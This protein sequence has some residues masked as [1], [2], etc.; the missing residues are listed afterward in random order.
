M[1]NFISNKNFIVVFLVF[2]FA[3]SADAATFT[4][5][6]TGDTADIS[7]GDGICADAAGVCTLRAAIQEANALAGTDT[8]A[9][10]ITGPGVQTISP[11]SAYPVI[12][13]PLLID[14][15][16]QGGAGYTGPPLI[17][18]NG[19]NAGSGSEGFVFTGGS[20]LLRGIVINRFPGNGVDLLHVGG[21]TVSGCYIGTDSGGTVDLGNGGH[22]IAIISQ[23]NTSS[24]NHIIG[25]STPVERNI[26]SGNAFKGI[27]IVGPSNNNQ[28]KG[29]FIGTD[30]TGTADLGNTHDGVEITTGPTGNIVGGALPGEGNLISGNSRSGIVNN[31][32]DS[33]IFLGNS[34]GTDVTGTADIGNTNAGVTIGVDSDNNVIGGVAPGEGNRI[35]FNERGV[36]IVDA[37]SDGHSIRGNS[38]FSNDNLGIEL[39]AFGVDLNDPDD[40]DTGANEQQNFPVINL[41]VSG[42]TI[43]RG[44]LNSAPNTVFSLDFYSTAVPDGSNHGE[45]ETYIGSTIVTTDAVGNAAFLAAFTQNT[46]VGHFITATATDPA[47]NTSEFSE[48]RQVLAPT[49]ANVTVGGRV[50][51][52][53]GRGVPNTE[54]LMTDNLGQTRIARTS[55]FG[56]YRFTDVPAGATY[57]FS[58]RHK[59]YTSTPL[60][61]F[62]EDEHDDINLEVK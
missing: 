32:A 19:T 26:I 21:N 52:S 10:A 60:A 54:V 29:N 53:N 11:A 2:L 57:I 46:P 43:I 31:A 5:V 61:V 4:V 38:I 17:E 62:V 33:N 6:S 37:A 47:G 15:W 12:S 36:R 34:I 8:V 22:G 20:S 24:S 49:S 35:A 58:V 16:T 51:T 1:F 41:A 48:A 9:F 27:H 25:G 59:I 28:I 45:G 50:V 3:V 18:L 39:G 7:P 14:G 55:S 13:Q 23:I 40:V 30:V 56:Y 44:T 42:S